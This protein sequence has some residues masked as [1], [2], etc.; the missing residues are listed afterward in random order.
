MDYPHSQPGVALRDGKFTDGNPLLSIPASRDP[1]SWANQVTEELLNVIRATGREPSEETDNQLLLS[2]VQ[3]INASVPDSVVT[4]LSADTALAAE[5]FGLV[6][7]DAAGGNRVLTLPAADEDLG[8]RDVI[9]RRTDV[10]ANTLT[11]AASGADKINWDM[12][13]APAGASSVQ[14]NGGGNWLHLRSDG[15]GRWYEIGAASLPP[16][17]IAGAHKNLKASAS[18]T[19]AQINVT[20]DSVVVENAA[21][22]PRLLRNINLTIN[23]AVVGPNGLSTGVLANSTWYAIWIWWNGSSACATLDLSATAPTAPAGGYT[24]RARVGWARTDASVNKYPMGFVQYGRDVQ[25]LA[26][27]DLASGVLTQWTPMAVGNFVPPTAGA[28]VGRI[29]NSNNI[30]AV[31]PNATYDIYGIS[32]VYLPPGY[33]TAAHQFRLQLES[34]NI[35]GYS[36]SAGSKIAVLGWEDNL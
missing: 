33:G 19:A 10:S 5:Q 32:Y 23:S 6:L 34:S 35:Y 13:V 22:Q 26:L 3:M 28:I 1:A 12:Q 15:A 29:N 20:A 4:V 17:S 2:I 14:V 11:V 36:T 16:A 9:I 31:A 8:V 24:H 25:Y 27:R 21:G 18:G 7:F 30:C